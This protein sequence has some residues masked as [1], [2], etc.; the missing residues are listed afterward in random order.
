MCIKRKKHISVLFLSRPSKEIDTLKERFTHRVI[1]AWLEPG[2]VRDV[3]RECDHGLLVREPTVTNS[4]AS[5][6][7]FAEYLCC[8]LPVIIS[9]HLGDFTALVESERL[10]IVVGPGRTV[11]P[12]GRSKA[13][14]QRMQAFALTHFKKAVHGPAYVHVLH[15][16][17]A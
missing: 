4:V 13:E 15:A 5:P 17:T 11:G 2:E 16:L 12:L 3:L 7:K 14:R 10:G 6:T 8:G 9:D 1:Q